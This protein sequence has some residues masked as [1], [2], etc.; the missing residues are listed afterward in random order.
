MDAEE[1]AAHRSKRVRR[2][3]RDVTDSACSSELTSA[4]TSGR[5]TPAEWQEALD[6]IQQM[7]DAV[8]PIQ[9]RRGQPPK[10][11][12]VAC[13]IALSR[14]EQFK[15][16]REALR[17]FGAHPE[18]KVREEWI[19]GKTP[20]EI[21]AGQGYAC[22]W[23]PPAKPRTTNPRRC[24]CPT[25]VTEAALCLRCF[26]GPVGAEATGMALLSW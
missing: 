6:V 8:P 10:P 1:G 16:D 24:E 3:A 21:A 2:P 25:Q 17:L 11:N 13:A 19:D 9:P 26:R 15:D 5:P 4:S 20:G 12:V 14:G 18:T 23:W 7:K 22:R